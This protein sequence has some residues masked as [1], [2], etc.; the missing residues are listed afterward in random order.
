VLVG[1]RRHQEGM[2]TACETMWRSRNYVVAALV[3]RQ[4]SLPRDVLRRS[5]AQYAFYLAGVAFWSGRY[6]ETWRWIRRARSLALGLS[7]SRYFVRTVARRFLPRRSDGPVLR[8]GRVLHDESQLPEPLVP[9]DRIYERIWRP[10]D[11]P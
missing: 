5:E 3:A 11:R 2:S 8:Q 6:G 9:Y 1:Y 4:P 7:L 10:P